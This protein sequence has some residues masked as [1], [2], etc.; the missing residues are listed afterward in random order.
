MLN[1]VIEYQAFK[2]IRRASSL[3]CCRGAPLLFEFWRHPEAYR[4]CFEL[5][6]HAT[7]LFKMYSKC[8]AVKHFLAKNKALTG[9]YLRLL[10][11]LGA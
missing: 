8:C 1:A 7:P 10:L 6:W 11:A 2:K 4:Y 5:F 3:T 9:H